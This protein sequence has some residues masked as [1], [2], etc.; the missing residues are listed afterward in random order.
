MQEVSTEDSVFASNDGSWF[1]TSCHTSWEYCESDQDYFSVQRH[2]DSH[3]FVI[4]WKDSREILQQVKTNFYIEDLAN[5]KKKIT[6]FGHEV[7]SELTHS[8]LQ[9]LAYRRGHK[10]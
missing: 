7:W 6:F 4:L 1:I 5:K 3:W 9:I 2:T 8:R 10:T